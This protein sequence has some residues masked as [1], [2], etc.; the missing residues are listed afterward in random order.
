MVKPTRQ[1]QYGEVGA[2]L[3]GAV[4][5]SHARGPEARVGEEV[6]D[7]GPGAVL[8]TPHVHDGRG[9]DQEQ[10]EGRQHEP[11]QLDHRGGHLRSQSGGVGARE[12]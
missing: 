9:R 6:C 1:S 5:R 4:R 3:G 7:D 11:D 8:Q 10:A 2:A 12:Q